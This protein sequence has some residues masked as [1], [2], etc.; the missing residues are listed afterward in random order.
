VTDNDPLA[1]RLDHTYTEDHGDGHRARDTHSPTAVPVSSPNLFAEVTWEKTDAP[2]VGDMARIL[3]AGQWD[4]NKMAHYLPVYE[5]AFGDRHRRVRVL[6]IGVNVGGSL[7]LWRKWF[8]NRGSVIVGIDYNNRCAQLEN[9]AKNIHIRIGKQQDTEFLQRVVEEFGP[10]DVILDDGSH[11]PSFTLK[12]FQYLFVNGLNDGGSYVVEDLH[13]CYSPDS[14]EPFPEGHP[15]LAD[16][17]DGSP[18]F[19]EFVKNLI[20]VMHAHW[21]Q[22]PTGLDIDKVEPDNP[23]RV[24]SFQV[25][26]AT[27]MI[28]S[29]EL[30]DAIVVIRRGEK[31]LPRMIRRWSEEKM[32]LIGKPDDAARFLY[33]KFPHLGEADKT[34]RD[35][36]SR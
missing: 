16:A 36:W 20:N 6:E 7:E 8:T 30:H 2:L 9:P 22:M 34:R 12:S 5:S 10:F 33:E 4:I 25:P 1:G 23:A 11:I 3:R 18:T 29:I 31:E 35:Y 19:T 32:S 15:E 17:N 28:K 13:A 27:K 21:V 24:D 26:W 14:C